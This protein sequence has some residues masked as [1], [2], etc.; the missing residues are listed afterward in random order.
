MENK[1][2]RHLMAYTDESGRLGKDNLF[3]FGTLWCERSTAR[4]M[5]S[6]LKQVRTDLMFNDTMHFTEMSN[7]RGE[8]YV[9]AARAVSAIPGWSM[10]VLI[11]RKTHDSS[12][13]P[14]DF[15]HYGQKRDPVALKRARAYNKLLHDHLSAIVRYHPASFWT[16][17]FEDRN[18]PR[19]DNGKEYIQR[20]L[21]SYY[22]KHVAFL[23]KRDDDLLQ[24]IDLLLGAYAE[25]AYR[26]CGVERA[27]PPGARKQRV[28]AEVMEAIRGHCKPA[29]VWTP[30]T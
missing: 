8:A 10:R 7:L 13:K 4:R 17:Y 3:F 23:P 20:A 5:R 27:F 11:Y 14:Y 26:T 22:V 12:G 2:P 19:D 1:P 24:V 16:L 21:E 6:A 25:Q 18:R 29:W 28:A 30:R 15:T 9:R